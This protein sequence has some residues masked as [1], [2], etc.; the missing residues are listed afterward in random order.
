MNSG[1]PEELAAE[2]RAELARRKLIDFAQAVLPWYEAPR[3]IRYL[4]E[5]LERVERGDIKRLAISAPPGH[6]KSTL[7]QAF[8][9]WFLGRDPRRRILALSASEAL[10]RRN[11]RATRGIVQADEW[12]WPQTTLVG[13]S[14]EEWYTAQGGG[15]RAIGQTGT[16]TGFRAEMV[17]CDDVQ[18][19]AGSET[20]RETLEEWFRGVLSTR[21]EP[22]GCAVLIATR[23]HDDDLVGRLQTGESASQWHFV[24]IEAIAGDADLFGRAPDEALWPERWPLELLEKKRAEVGSNAFACQYQGD[25]VPAGGAIFKPEWFPRYDSLPSQ[26]VFNETADDIARRH[27]EGQYQP[28]QFPLVTIQAADSAWKEGL[29]HDRSA[30]AT[31][32]T[33]LR[34]IYVVDLWFG[35]VEYPDLKRIAKE[36]YSKHRPRSLYVEEAAS[37]Y[38]LV[39]D[40][41]SSTG[42]PIIGIPPGREA[43]E[44]R[45]E[46]VTGL[47]EAGRVKFPRN[48]SWMPELLAEFLRF[49]Y[50]RHDDIVDAVVLGIRQ[51]QQLISRVLTQRAMQQQLAGFT[52]MER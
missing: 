15:V 49:P 2:A 13:E 37:G 32:T 25:P 17:L 41:K 45:A 38:A 1:V 48:A 47:F 7:L 24:N 19:D 29:T 42:I 36:V 52:L 51:M 11:S 35:R 22:D 4:A 28:P 8:L 50:G 26:C 10:A 9:A 20:T 44:A 40:L 23:W 33:D 6:G 3:H 43:K 39:A 16:V 30:I 21:L 14:L 5:L 27:L 46:S 12:P 31:L 34:D 18:P